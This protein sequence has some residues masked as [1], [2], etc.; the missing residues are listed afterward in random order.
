M[1]LNARF[2]RGSALLLLSLLFQPAHAGGVAPYLPVN[3][4]PI[5]ENEVER[6]ATLAGIPNL[7]KP[8][9][10]ATIYEYLERIKYS[11]P[12]LYGRLND[13]LEPYS[14]HIGFTHLAASV[15]HADRE[16]NA[17]P[18][19]L[20]NSYG[21]D[22]DIDAVARAR[23]HWQINDSAAIYL[24]AQLAY[25]PDE[26]N[27][28]AQASGSY[29]AFGTSWA[30]L[31][32]GY[33]EYWWSP[34]QGSAQILSTQAKTFPSISLSNNLPIELF[35]MRWNYAT[36]IG[37]TSKQNVR[38]KG[39]WS[40]DDK[41]YLLGAHLSVQ[42]TPWW[43]IGASRTLQ[44]GGGKRP[45]SLSTL[46]E[47]FVDASSADNTNDTT[48]TDTENGNQMAAIQS[49]MNFDGAIPFSVSVELAGEDTSK[50]KNY[51]LGNTSI[52][53]G[54]YFPY[55][56]HRSLS[57]NYEY[58]EWQ[59]AWYAHHLY[60][61]G[62]VNEGMVMGHWAMQAQR[63]LGLARPGS[64]QFLRLLW[65]TPWDH[66]LLA[67]IRTSEHENPTVANENTVLLDKAQFLELEYTIPIDSRAITIGSYIGEDN[68][69]F[70]IT[71][72]YL[73]MSW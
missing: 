59:R 21:I 70:D 43:T 55:F 30:Q 15:G 39:E 61:Q 60:E 36:F 54:V 14:A 42:P 5:L 10:L 26:A 57:L 11:H 32:I 48:T 23:L 63:E 64:S 24:G 16:E 47:A 35:G 62:Y 9:N 72:L 2:S 13:A 45:V 18:L 7:T 44:F 34:M 6:L 4:S 29:L 17:E 1:D 3:I 22:S 33:Q 12:D 20:P 50:S 40:N 73:K 8:Y 69:G 51:Q 65:Q 53:V 27:G 46:F 19:A 41:P 37:Q 49:K 38:Y 68:F 25:N 56:I 67:S 58:S 28:E 52:G 71:Q 31:N 66:M